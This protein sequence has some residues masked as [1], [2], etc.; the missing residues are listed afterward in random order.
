MNTNNLS[1]KIFILV[2][3]SFLLGAIS[4]FGFD[5]LLTN[6]PL[7]SQRDTTIPNDLTEDLAWVQFESADD[8]FQYLESSQQMAGSFG[9][10]MPFGAG[11]EIMRQM[12]TSVANDMAAPA[13]ESGGSFSTTNVRVGG[14]DEPDI[15]K[16]DGQSL[17]I[18]SLIWG[19]IPRP[20]PM[21]IDEPAIM[22]MS[23]SS[24]P[25]AGSATDSQEQRLIAPV[26]PEDFPQAQTRILTAVDPV[27]S[28]SST[29]DVQGDL[30]L[31]EDTLVILTNR[32]L[33]AYNVSQV[34]NPSQ[35]WSYDY[36]DS[37]L[38]S[39]RLVDNQLY[40]IVQKYTDRYNSANQGCLTPLMTGT[41]EIAIDC[42]TI[43]H[44]TRPVSNPVTFTLLKLDINTGE[45]SNQESYMSQAGQTHIYQSPNNIYLTTS[46]PV[47][48]T[49]VIPDFY[50]SLRGQGILPDSLLEQIDRVY[51]LDISNPAKEVEVQ[52]ILSDYYSTQD[53]SRGT[54]I[55]EQVQQ[56]QENYLSDRVRQLEKT[57]VVRFNLDLQQQAS[58]EI[59]G[60]LV[61]EFAI[62]EYNDQIRVATT[63]G[64]NFG[65]GDSKNDIYVYDLNGQQL[66][67]IQDLA[68]TE[69]IYSARFINESLYLVT[70]RQI[71]PFF[72]IDMSDPSNLQVQGELKIPGF[73]SYLHPISE[74]QI[75][76]VGAQD[77]GLK[78]SL[79]DVSDSSNPV[80]TD[81]LVFD[82]YS[83]TTFD[84]RAFLFDSDN[85]RIFVPSNDGRGYFV[86]IEDSGLTELAE[87]NQINAQRAVYAA[88]YVFVIGNDG[89]IALDRL[90]LE[91]VERVN[92]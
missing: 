71:D 32:G 7:L 41:A 62:D 63:L 39:A 16:T 49:Q 4:Y 22:P 81:N 35:S 14:I 75:L 9:S 90:S 56:A 83:G 3:V 18:S 52:Q 37:S 17:F 70:F 20:L 60:V 69:R 92:F 68:I 58:F 44:P 66:G 26:P 54:P 31:K 72:V 51:Q 40:L 15:V 65:L 30:L 91:Q 55:Y 67:Q 8:Y 45:V 85:Q 84:H 48:I 89:V 42:T 74:T 34:D 36:Q 53:N 21:P 79:F 87:V 64:R 25:D 2:L 11:G 59:P 43:Y 38:V 50:R 78:V 27:L 86:Q 82:G 88:D 13:E 61:N 28:E 10:G 47:N 19:G 77:G 5:Y 73:S 33:E 12:E 1:A 6:M 24:A 57:Q 76:G 29:I 46:L 23:E 80:E